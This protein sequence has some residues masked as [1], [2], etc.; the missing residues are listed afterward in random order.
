MNFFPET[1]RILLL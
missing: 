1:N